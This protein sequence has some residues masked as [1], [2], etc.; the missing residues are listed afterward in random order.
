MYCRECGSVVNDKA[1]ICVKCGCRPNIDHSYCQECG[2]PTK[3]VV[4]L[5]LIHI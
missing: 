1:E 2:S 4:G 3:E 5:S